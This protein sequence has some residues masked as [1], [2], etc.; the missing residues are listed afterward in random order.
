MGILQ[1]VFKLN[2]KLAWEYLLG[3]LMLND[4]LLSVKLIF[5]KSDDWM[6]QIMLLFINIQKIPRIPLQ[7]LIG[8]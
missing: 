5:T 6:K 3:I 7:K 1:T 2:E 8:I 4:F